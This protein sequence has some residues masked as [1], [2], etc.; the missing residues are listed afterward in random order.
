MTNHEFALSDLAA[1]LA[2]TDASLSTSLRDIL[3]AALQELIEAELTSV[4]G[5]GHGERTS[6]RV[7]QRNGHRPKL[8]STPAGDAGSG[9]CRICVRSVSAGLA[10]RRVG[11]VPSAA[12]PDPAGW[13]LPKGR[14]TV[15]SSSGVSGV[16]V[17]QAECSVRL[18]RQAAWQRSLASRE[19]PASGGAAT[20]GWHTRRPARLA[21]AAT[22]IAP[23]S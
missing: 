23:R 6:E 8:L 14:I 13:V 11:C 16:M 2:G 10:S 19:T 3:A 20:P 7:N 18:W 22:G 9:R 1:R 15:R 21:V 4:I 12:E 17:W 5:A